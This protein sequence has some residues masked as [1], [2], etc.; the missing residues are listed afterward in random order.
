MTKKESFDKVGIIIQ[1]LRL[2]IP[3]IKIM[4][5]GNKNDLINLREI[6]TEEI[7]TFAKKYKVLSFETSALTG[8][9]IDFSFESLQEDLISFAKDKKIINI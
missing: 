3:S 1:E 5:I 4:I 9:N 2:V 8:K 6:S 7:L